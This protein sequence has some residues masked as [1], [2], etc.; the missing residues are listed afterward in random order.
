MVLLPGSSPDHVT[1]SEIAEMAGVGP[2]AVS[3]WRRRRPD[4]P[5][6]TETG[7][8]GDLFDYQR[9]ARWLMD[10]KKL[11]NPRIV[12]HDDWASGL[13]DAL[14]AEH[15][16][17][18]AAVVALQ[19]LIARA[20]LGGAMPVADPS[21]SGVLTTVSRVFP[22]AISEEVTPLQQRVKMERIDPLPDRSDW[23]AL[24]M[25][26]VRA[27]HDRLE[28]SVDGTS[29]PGLI[30]V[31][32]AALAP[33]EGVLY[34]PAAGTGLTLALLALGAAADTEMDTEM[35]AESHAA[36]E[37]ESHAEL[38]RDMD[39]DR[40]ADM[41]ADARPSGTRPHHTDRQRRPLEIVGQE[42]NQS[43]GQIACLNLILQEIPFHIESGDTL[44]DD[45]FPSLRADRIALEPPGGMRLPKGLDPHD[46]RWDGLQ[47]PRL[48]ELFWVLHAAH[49][50]APGGRAAIAL[51]LTALD[52]TGPDA[53]ILDILLNHD[54][55]DAVIALPGGLLAGSGRLSVLLILER[56]RRNRAGQVLFVDATSFGRLHRGIPL[57][58]G[59]G[60]GGEGEI[61][62]AGLRK[63]K[64][65]L[66]A[67][68]AGDV[69]VE[70]RF[71]AV[72]PVSE[73]QTGDGTL[74]PRRF[75]RYLGR[76]DG[77]GVRAL[78]DRYEAGRSWLVRAL[79]AVP[80]AAADL[81]RD[82]P[83]LRVELA[84]REAGEAEEVRLGDV[85][86][87]EL[88]RGVPVRPQQPSI[89]L[90][91][92]KIGDILQSSGRLRALPDRDA[93]PVLEGHTIE[94]NDILLGMK[95]GSDPRDHGRI[96]KVVIADFDGLAGLGPHMTRLRPYAG[97]VDPQYLWLLLNSPVMS[98]ALCAMVDA[99]PLLGI[100]PSTLQDLRIQLPPLEVQ[101]ALA[102]AALQ[103]ETAKAHLESA[104]GAIVALEAAVGDAIA[105]GVLGVREE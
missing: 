105:H 89:R 51:P 28:R 54:L 24:G 87:S 17:R 60:G 66:S 104:L 20:R 43:F 34:D 98:E 22:G 68:R 79:E 40:D 1:A 96:V 76:V 46:V 88:I 4:F 73:V 84:L 81:A 39:A 31:L 18:S 38:D 15:D 50:L 90:P 44:L 3:N 77:D 9:V 48:A 63:I 95:P 37:A 41:D 91:V 19:F 67:W 52:R 58:G 80:G 49:H 72:A 12:T 25:A 82:L 45:R 16:P 55:V 57:G 75:I 36:A 94:R 71:S 64:R 62:P 30:G 53:Q 103:T 85:L 23:G 14:M 83:A 35:A 13:L 78:S 8:T 70:D 21:G 29:S 56:G 102:T 86:A 33:V 61:S 32:G 97:A 42:I 2:S 99:P 69:K 47:P 7:P 101:Q 92:V 93:E 10:N 11:A 65:T 74:L 6:P 100:R 27:F 5:L 59:R 26:V